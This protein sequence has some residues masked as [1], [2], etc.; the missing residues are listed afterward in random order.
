MQGKSNSP[1]HVTIGTIVDK[2]KSWQYSSLDSDD[3]LADLEKMIA[4]VEA[5]PDDSDPDG[6]VAAVA[7]QLQTA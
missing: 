3:L 4:E 1:D 6:I 5:G 2:L 7:A